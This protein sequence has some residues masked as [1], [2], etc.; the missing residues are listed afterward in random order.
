M[1]PRAAT[2]FLQDLTDSLIVILPT[3]ITVVLLAASEQCQLI[4]VT[5]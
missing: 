1:T 4:V 3:P 2:G 5:F